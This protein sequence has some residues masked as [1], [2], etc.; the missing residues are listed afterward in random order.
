MSFRN[1]VMMLMLAANGWAQVQC[2]APR[3]EQDTVA[4]PK[5]AWER[6]LLLAGED[7]VRRNAA[8]LEVPEPV[9]MRS[10]I[11]AGPYE[12]N[13][14]RLLVRA[15]PERGYSGIRI[16]TGQCDVIP[17]AERVAAS[18][19]QIDIFFNW[20]AEEILLRE[21]PKFEGLVGGYPMYNGRIYISK[22]GRLPWKPVTVRDRL[23]VE[24]K[25]REE[26]L[27]D[28]EKQKARRKLPDEAQIQKT[29]A[30]LKSTDAA[31]ADRYLKGMRDFAETLRQEQLKDPAMDAQL[32]QGVEDCRRRLESLSAAE[33]D[34]PAADPVAFKPDPDF[35][36]AK[37]RRME[38]ITVLYGVKADPRDGSPRA[39]WMRRAL[40]ALDFKA[41]AA[42]LD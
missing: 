15:Y 29:Y 11:A 32:R 3:E 4:G 14:G 25:R 33:L 22:D 42:M 7:L 34:S 26:R 2:W 28:W 41:L 6:K 30:M 38:L 12:H 19:G 9:R 35:P 5:F 10:T 40:A 16:W 39:V 23:T 24:L 37:T 36:S 18:I 17:Q 21:P 20:P 8:F 1:G 31:G 13:R 27:A